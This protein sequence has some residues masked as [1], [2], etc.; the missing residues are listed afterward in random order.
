MVAR[1]QR[2]NG[3][4]A[5][6][7]E[8]LAILG[9]LFADFSR[10]VSDIMGSVVG[11][12]ELHSEDSPTT[13]TH[14]CRPTAEQVRAIVRDLAANVLSFCSPF[15][16]TGDTVSDA[17]QATLQLYQHRQ[18]R[19]VCFQYAEQ[20]DLP[21]VTISNGELQ[22]ILASMIKNGLNIA[23]GQ[24]SPLIRITTT[25]TPGAV[26]VTVWNSGPV[27]PAKPI[28]QLI[29]SLTR[30]HL[31]DANTGLG[32][33]VA[34]RLAS[35]AGGSI[36]ARIINTG[37]AATLRLPTAEHVTPPQDL[38]VPEQGALKGR[39]VLVVDDDPPTRNVCELM[40]RKMRQAQ[41]RSCAS[42]ME[43]LEIL[44][45]EQFDA[46]IMDLWMPGLSGQEVYL[47]MSKPLRRCVVF[48]TGA[49]VWSMTNNFL[50]STGQPALFKP[51][52]AA[53]LV[54]AVCQVIAAAPTRKP[55]VKYAAT[56]SH[57]PHTVH[58]RKTTRLPAPSP[59]CPP[60]SPL[61]NSRLRLSPVEI[62]SPNAPHPSLPRRHNQPITNNK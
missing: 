34:S 15:E 36:S 14:A 44:G 7:L 58:R 6:Q 13:A 53:S 26:S 11:F 2:S 45:I 52:T 22:L 55:G 37:V 9:D 56:A 31:P 8:G 18:R 48:L 57:Y 40:L 5:A 41:V 29:G 59:L 39:R 20:A 38:A 60:L 30:N 43:A 32:L 46:I 51:V 10:E 25:S 49:A 33:L 17:V 3:G 50:N 23:A 1:M 62:G 27:V 19:G 61:T 4:A 28:N 35:R 21:P 42:G 16:P 47:K 54:S 12:P 24:D